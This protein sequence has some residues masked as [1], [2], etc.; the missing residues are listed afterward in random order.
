MSERTRRSVFLAQRWRLFDQS[1]N[2]HGHKFGMASIA[3]KS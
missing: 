3:S 2:R 1:L